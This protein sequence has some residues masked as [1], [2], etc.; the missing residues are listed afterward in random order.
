MEM[1]LTFSIYLRKWFRASLRARFSRQ[2][3]WSGLEEVEP[4]RYETAQAPPTPTISFYSGILVFELCGVRIEFA[5]AHFSEV[6]G[7]SCRRRRRHS[8][9]AFALGVCSNRKVLSP[10]YG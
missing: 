6:T 1:I 2:R 9:F 3:V 10:R 4:A 8:S 7:F 5:N